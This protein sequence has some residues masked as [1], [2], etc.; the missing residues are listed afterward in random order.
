MNTTDKHKLSLNLDIIGFI[1]SMTCAVHCFLMPF[2]I[3]TISYY[4]FS[5]LNNSLFELIFI[6]IILIIGLFTFRHGYLKHHK[7]LLPS[8]LFIT[9]IIVIITSHYFYH[10][11]HEHHEI[12]DLTENF[13]LFIITPLG[14]LLIAVSHYVNRKLTKKKNTVSCSC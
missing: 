9:G 10:E 11:H 4:G 8:I 14:A 1:A 3:I 7:S 12:N 5:F 13:L 6:F 2:I